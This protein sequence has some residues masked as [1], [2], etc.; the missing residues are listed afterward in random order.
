MKK[1]FLILPV[2]F[3]ALSPL[4]F[5]QPTLPPGQVPTVTIDIWTFLNKLLNWFFGIVIVLAAL[6]FVYAGYTF[7]MAAGDA[8]K[9]KTALN[10]LIYGL[11]GVA[12]ALMAK[13]LVYMICTFVGAT[14]CKFW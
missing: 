13:G 5:G 14:A 4:A 11:V 10:T 2:L 1:L 7:I 6:M 3:I 12:V 8:A 9:I